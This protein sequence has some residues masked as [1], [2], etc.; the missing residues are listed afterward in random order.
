[1]GTYDSVEAAN[2]AAEA[3]HAYHQAIGEAEDALKHLS[4][5]QKAQQ[6]LLTDIVR[7]HLNNADSMN[8]M[9]T[10]LP[11]NI[12]SAVNA[13][14]NA[15]Q[16]IN[17][18]KTAGKQGYIGV[19][20]FYNIISTSSA[21]LESAG[22]DFYIKG[23]NASELMQLAAENVKI[24]NGKLSIDLSSAG[25]N[26]VSGVDEMQN[27]MKEGI[28]EL[29][30]AEINIIDAEIQVLE[31]LAMMEE[32]DDII[33]DEN[34]NGITFEIGDMFTFEDDGNIDGF[35]KTMSTYLEK[36]KELSNLT[37]ESKQALSNLI[38][39]G[40][41]FY[42]LLQSSDVNDWLDAFGGP[43]GMSKFFQKFTQ[44]DWRDHLDDIQGYFMDI[45]TGL[46]VDFEVKL[47]DEAGTF[48]VSGGTSFVIDYK[49][50][51]AMAAAQSAV[52]ALESKRQGTIQEILES[53]KQDKDNTELS[54]EDQAEVNVILGV[55]IGKIRVKEVKDDKGNVTGFESVYNGHRFQGGTEKEVLEQVG[56]AM[57]FE[58]QGYEVEYDAGTQTVTGV[59]HISKNT[60]LK[61][62]GN[63]YS[64]NIDGPSRSGMGNNGQFDT[65]EHAL[66]YLAAN[67]YGDE[68]DVGKTFTSSDN[69][70]W[71]IYKSNWKLYLYL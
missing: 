38:L 68:S 59:K 61:F 31:I 20:D 57:T 42:D 39:N 18:L 28:H 71:T 14:E 47:P 49:D 37:E 7:Q 51:E 34:D 58:E 30:R 15:S 32:L 62:D 44:E 3:Y 17:T 43:E 48:T 52:E 27:N 4:K 26:I 65:E 25:M 60:V 35:S 63:K 41:S 45:L 2:A 67:G 56:K 40:K 55:A 64:V 46:G 11:E 69:V 53:Y 22:R 8:F 12:Q 16:A 24:V 13:W 1:M 29:A 10:A 5:E 23:M 36:F 19:Q 70:E 54:F 50:E 66:A 6:N 33:V 21:L 9:S